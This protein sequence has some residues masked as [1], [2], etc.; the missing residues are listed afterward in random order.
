MI[1]LYHVLSFLNA[2][3]IQTKGGRNEPIGVGIDRKSHFQL[4]QANG[5]YYDGLW[6]RV[7]PHEEV[8]M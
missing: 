5:N 6:Q 7:P 2:I 8:R 3:L 4:V 1:V